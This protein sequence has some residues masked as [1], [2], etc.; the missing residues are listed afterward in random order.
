MPMPAGRRALIRQTVAVGDAVTLVA[1]FGAAYFYVGL[2]LH[3]VFV[4]SVSN[5]GLIALIVP[6]WL[7]CLRELGLYASAAYSS[8][9]DLLGRLVRT[10]FVAGLMLLAVMYATRSESVSRFLLHVFLIISFVALTAQK[11]ALRAYLDY[12]R[13]RTPVKRPKVLLIAA[14]ASAER[15][16]RLVNG[17]ASML[18]EVVGILTPSETNSHCGS[19]SLPPVLGTAE[20]LPLVLHNRVVDEVVVAASMKQGTLE[21]LSRCCSIRGI[22]LRILVELPRP[23]LGLWCSDYLGDGAFMLSLST[24]PQNAY[25]LAF[26]RIVD[27]IGAAIGLLV[28][29]ITYLCYGPRLRRESGATVLFRQQRVG[30]NGRR[31]TLYKF[32]TMRADSEQLKKVLDARNEMNGPI[33]KLKDDPRVTPT[34]RKLRRRHLDELPQFWNVLKGDMSLVG[35][36]PPTDDETAAYLEH[37]QRR[38]SI[39]PGLTGLWQLNGNGAIKDFEEVVKLDCEYIDNWSLWLDAK[40]VAKTVSKVMRGDAW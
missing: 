9:R 20:E 31:F 3:R 10:H 18:T 22:L 21:Q 16:I 17:H 35:T 1:S 19:G 32:R 24:V 25:H 8:S 27:V 7:I 15:Y 37:H 26:K 34:G 23:F 12:V 36:R 29:A 39:K 28:C 2:F 4:P 33:F 5:V 6:I 14:T 38:L 13:R 40:I 30:W 11:F